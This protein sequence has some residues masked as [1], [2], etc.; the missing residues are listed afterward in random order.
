[1]PVDDAVRELNALCVKSRKM[2]LGGGIVRLQNK[3]GGPVV[4][5]QR[6]DPKTG[7]LSDSGW[8]SVTQRGR[9]TYDRSGFLIDARLRRAQVAQAARYLG[10]SRHPWV[11]TKDQFGV[12][13][14]RS[15]RQFL[16]EDLLAPD[17]FVDLDS[18]TVPA[19]PQRCASHLLPRRAK[20]SVH[21]SPDGTRWTLSYLLRDPAGVTQ[22]NATL[23]VEGGLIRSGSTRMRGADG[24][25]GPDVDNA[26]RW[27]YRRPV[28]RLPERSKV[29]SQR[30]WIR[31]T[32]AAAL[33]TDLRFLSGSLEG[34]RSVSRL[35][36][37]AW[38]TVK[39]A[40]RGHAVRIRVRE[41]AGGVMLWGRNPY[42]G[43]VV[44]FQIAIQ[45]RPTAVAR[46]LS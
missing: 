15:F 26:A 46:R 23:D 3:P 16:R 39:A 19:Q 38:R 32:D 28:V 22:V 4:Q 44:A 27:V 29:V 37:V 35:R 14:S 25:L 21:R 43:Q 10:Y 31:A 12:L 7:R 8:P 13:A 36:T 20:A 41:V 2:F 30:R 42:S 6:Y 45:S 9:G 1:V 18:T 34:R 40:N 24:P 11:L 5:V 17:R 33:V